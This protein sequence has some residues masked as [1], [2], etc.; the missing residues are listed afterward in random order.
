M[1]AQDEPDSAAAHRNNILT[2]IDAAWRFAPGNRIYGEL[3]VD[4]LHSETSANPDK[5]A[6]QVGWEGTGTV[7]GRRISWNGEVTRV[8]RYV[9]TSFFGRVHE[10]QGRTLGFPTGPDSRRVRVRAIWDPSVDWQAMVRVTHTDRGE[11]SLDEPYVPGTPRP[12]ASTFEGVVERSREVE[13]GLRWWP[14][15]GVDL[16]VRG[17]WRQIDD[18]QHVAG[19]SRSDWTGA[20]ELRLVR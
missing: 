18:R 4:D 5:I 17:A 2:G 12:D 16:A 3:V 20:L 8:W 7:R 15:A 13:L 11:N 19:A 9:Y 1:L 6:W 14:S 10:A